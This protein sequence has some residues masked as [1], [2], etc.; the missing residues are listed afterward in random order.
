LITVYDRWLI[1]RST[2]VRGLLITGGADAAIIP[3]LESGPAM[4][5]K[6]APALVVP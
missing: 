5:T 2:L 3:A 1:L 6:P 4:A